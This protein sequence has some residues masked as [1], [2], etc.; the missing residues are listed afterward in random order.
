MYLHIFIGSL[1][2]KFVPKL[3]NCPTQVR[4][5]IEHCQDNIIKIVDLDSP[6]LSDTQIPKDQPRPMK[7]TSFCYKAIDEIY[8]EQQELERLKDQPE[9]DYDLEYLQLLNGYA[10]GDA[11]QIQKILDAE[12]E[13]RS[14]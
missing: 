12:I 3:E 13:V 9:G 11:E 7:E 14:S 10:Q 2:K 8:R 5:I 1:D 4:E 6:S